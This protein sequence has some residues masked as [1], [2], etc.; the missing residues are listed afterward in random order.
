M[1]LKIY[2]WRIFHTCIQHYK[3][4]I[5][6]YS[7]KLINLTNWQIKSISVDG[8]DIMSETYTFGKQKLSVMVP[9][10]KTIEIAKEKIKEY[11]EK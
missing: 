10:E 9:D 11:L 3:C 8:T 6:R 7:V 4:S 2:N 5:L 1:I